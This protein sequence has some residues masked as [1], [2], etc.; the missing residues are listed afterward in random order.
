MDS[1]IG[2]LLEWAVVLLLVLLWIVVRIICLIV[3]VWWAYPHHKWLWA[4][5]AITIFFAVLAFILNNEYI[6]GIAIA[7]FLALA[8]VA[9]IIECVNAQTYLDGP[10]PL[11]Q[12]VL[13]RRWWDMEVA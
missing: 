8:L 11:V 9:K 3:R 5:T 6:V 2:I 4:M 1:I 12:L 10:T 7:A 13:H